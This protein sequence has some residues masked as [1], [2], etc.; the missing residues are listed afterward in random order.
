MTVTLPP[1]REIAR[2]E[3][4]HAAALML[5]CMTPECVRIDWPNETT[6]GLTTIDW[7]DGIDRESARAVLIAI[8]LG[9][10]TEQYDGWD[11]WPI[12]PD[13]IAVAA[14]RDAEQARRLVEYLKFDMVD[15]AQIRWEANRLGGSQDFSRLAVAIADELEYRE[16]LHREDL[17][18]IHREVE[19][20]NT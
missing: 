19:L 2:H 12:D 15:W 6:A 10:M 17:E 9:G 11:D 18:R 20:C 7:G 4:Y 1:T 13:R 14:R 8:V 5:A 16:V 3:A